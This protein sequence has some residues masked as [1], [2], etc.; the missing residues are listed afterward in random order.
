MHIYM[1]VVRFQRK[2]LIKWGNGNGDR[3]NQTG[4]VNPQPA[5]QLEIQ[6]IHSEQ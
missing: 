6:L 3:T 5:N 4:A 2:L 1:C